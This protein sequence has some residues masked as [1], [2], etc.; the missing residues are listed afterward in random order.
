MNDEWYY[1]NSE[2]VPCGTGCEAQHADGYL[3]TLDVDH[4]GLHEAQIP[5]RSR[6]TGKFRTVETWS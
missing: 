2:P 5:Y 3:C 6:I 1:D 4:G